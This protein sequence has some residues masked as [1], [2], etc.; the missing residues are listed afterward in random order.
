MRPR[1]GAAI[2]VLSTWL[3]AAAAAS[4][5]VALEGV[6]PHLRASA[7][8]RTRGEVYD[9]FDPGGGATNEYAFGGA[10]ARAGLA[11]RSEALDIVA[12]G[13]T[14]ALFGLPDGAVA[15][16][17][18]G[19]LGL[20]ANY[21]QNNRRRDDAGVF[22][23]Q[24]FAVV[25]A[26]GI[27]G[28]Y[29]KGGRFEFSD[30]AEVAAADPTLDWLKSNR[31]AQRLIGPFGFSHV[32]RSFDGMAAGWTR[33]ALNA[34]VMASHPTQGGF[35]LAGNKEIAG[36]DLG[37]LALNLTRPSFAPKSD[38]RI[39][40]IYY[41]DGRGL[42]KADNRPADVRAADRRHIEIHSQGANWLQVVPSP[43]GPF[44]VLFWGVV[45]EG[46]WGR[47][48]QRSWAWDAEVG[49]QP[50]SLAWHPW[51]RIGFGRSSGD[52]DPG[53][54]EH[55]T[56]FQI[57]PTARIYALST[58][59]DLQNDADAFASILLRPLP[60]L[61]SRTDFHDVRLSSGRDLFYS[62]SGATEAGRNAGFGYSGRPASGNTGLFRV[63]ETSLSYDWTSRLTIG[64]Y[65]G[66][67]F[68]G[69]V[70]RSLFRDAQANFGF[71]ETTIR[72]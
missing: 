13:Q 66:H 10:L 72:L 9:Y 27:G 38:A 65:Y 69:D 5:E 33:A 58:F 42:L 16:P 45:Q 26:L 2:L 44:D 35:D 17:P 7:S 30:G 8:L 3:G 11:W 53:D 47:L 20:G 67:L 46:S 21:F 12:E 56:F 68:G 19:A 54:A 48:A 31:I 28:A 62:G 57:L 29:V 37:Y 40:Y 18:A 25:K 60:G 39:F 52:G 14:S 22:L 36:I 34:T 32:G 71:V 23:K 15:P 61:V 50:V 41:A 63:V 55:Q 4:A 70:I 64:A 51:V 43:A 6:S 1:R 24:G 49:W 59:Y